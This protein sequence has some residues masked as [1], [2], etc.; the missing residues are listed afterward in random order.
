MESTDKSFLLWQQGHRFSLGNLFLLKYVAH[1]LHSSHSA[2]K[3]N[4]CDGAD[5][6]SA[7]ESTVGCCIRTLRV[8]CST[9]YV[10]L[11]EKHS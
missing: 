7:M 2:N 4:D 5:R 8:H 6:S 1:H 3:S 9:M 10:I 11:L